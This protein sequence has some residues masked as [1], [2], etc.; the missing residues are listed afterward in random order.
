MGSGSSDGSS[1]DSVD[2]GDGASDAEMPALE[3]P[4]DPKRAHPGGHIVHSSKKAALAAILKRKSTPGMGSAT[5]DQLRAAKTAKLL[6][7]G[8]NMPVSWAGDV[9]HRERDDER[10]MAFKRR[11]RSAPHFGDPYD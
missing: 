5:Q 7:D 2:S 10:H 4:R 9:V 3:S 11:A 8:T 1:S 6:P